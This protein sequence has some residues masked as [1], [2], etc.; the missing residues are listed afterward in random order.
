MSKATEAMISNIETRFK[1]ISK[2]HEEE[3]ER[4]FAVQNYGFGALG[5]PRFKTMNKQKIKQKIKFN[6]IMLSDL[7]SY[8]K[9]Y[10]WGN[11][12]KTRAD[13]DIL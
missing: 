1:E 5:F 7:K 6:D 4:W 9:Q 10:A 13:E 12:T 3:N 11:T 8:P 2:K